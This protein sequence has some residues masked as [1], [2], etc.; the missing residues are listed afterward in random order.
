M[1]MDPRLYKELIENKQGM[2]S[3]GSGLGHVSRAPPI[4]EPMPPMSPAPMPT[5]LTGAPPVPEVAPNFAPPPPFTS[6]SVL[7]H[8][9]NSLGATKPK[10]GGTA[11]KLGMGVL[12]VGLGYAAYRASKAIANRAFESAGD[13]V[14]PDLEDD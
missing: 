2:A 9:S 13:D 8:V 3:D 6:G 1:K 4:P 7:P 10:M 12:A 14:M 11:K 5:G